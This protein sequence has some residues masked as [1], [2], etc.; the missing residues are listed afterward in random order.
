L[1]M[2]VAWVA[3]VV[4]L[5]NV[6][7]SASGAPGGPCGNNV[8]QAGDFFVEVNGNGNVPKFK[9]WFGE[10]STNTYSLMFQQMFEAINGSKYGPSNIALPSLTWTWSAFVYNESG[11]SYNFN[12]TAINQGHGNKQ[13]FSMFQLRNHL[14]AANVSKDAYVKFDVVIDNYTWVSTDISAQLVLVYQMT[15]NGANGS[16]SLRTK[17]NS[18]GNG[19]V[20]FQITP[21]ADSWTGTDRSKVTDVSAFLSLQGKDTIWLTY[22]HFVGNLVHDPTFGFGNPGGGWATWQIALVVIVVLVAVILSVGI[23]GFVLWRRNRA[24][25]RPV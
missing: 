2:K 4:V 14:H 1:E 3:F 17:S 5:V 20:Y 13:Q 19:Q 25:Y 24:S 12:I 9:F 8:C 11:N 18:V 22:D 15:V 6:V 16:F 21:T 10:N 7:L 23:G